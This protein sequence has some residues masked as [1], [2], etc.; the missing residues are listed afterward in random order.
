MNRQV[1]EYLKDFFSPLWWVDKLGG[2]VIT[3]RS[4][5]K[6]FPVEFNPDVDVC[7]T[8][9]NDYVPDDSKK[10]IIYFEDRGFVIGGMTSRYFV[11]T[12]SLRLVCWLNYKLLDEDTYEPDEFILDVLNA[13]PAHFTDGNII[14]ATVSVESVSETDIFSIYSYNID[15][16][17]TFYPYGAFAVDISVKYRI[18]KDCFN[19]QEGLPDECL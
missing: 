17:F 7:E 13:F 11:A 19:S 16:Q 18:A 6:A 4:G 5:E 2:M 10:S 12:T 9:F 3:A 14:G 1:A 8:Q 15:K